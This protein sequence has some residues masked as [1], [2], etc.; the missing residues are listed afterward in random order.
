MP[1]QD[2]LLLSQTG[3][4]KMA[5]PEAC[6]PLEQFTKIKELELV[7]GKAPEEEGVERERGV[8]REKGP[9]GPR[10]AE[11]E[12]PRGALQTQV[13]EGEAGLGPAPAEESEKQILTLQAV[14][15]TP[16]AVELQDVDWLTSQHQDGLQVL[17][18]PGGGLESLLWVEDEA[19]QS[20]HPC[21]AINIPEEVY[22]LPELGLMQFHVLE[23]SVAVAVA[24]GDGAL[25]ASPEESTRLIKVRRVL[26][27]G[28][29]TWA[30]E[31]EPRKT[32]NGFF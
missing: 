21:V 6:D 24:G 9:S 25:V 27:N 16:D 31:R 8:R 4:A 1:Y 12:L 30:G 2:C 22:S 11:A 20:L 18:P 17:V 28:P 10:E 7:P 3:Q 5:G 23:E 19:Q 26:K 13:P 15:L 14:S 29:L 32:E